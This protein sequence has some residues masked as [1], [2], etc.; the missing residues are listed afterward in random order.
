MDSHPRHLRGLSTR[1]CETTAFIYGLG[2][3]VPVHEAA[4][5]LWALRVSLG[6]A[7]GENR[8]AYQR[9]PT[10]DVQRDAV[11]VRASSRGQKDGRASDVGRRSCSPCGDGF[12]ASVCARMSA[13]RTF[14]H[15]LELVGVEL[16]QLVRGGR[17]LA[18]KQARRDA[19]DSDMQ[20]RETSS[21]DLCQEHHGSLG[22]LC[23]KVAVSA[24]GR[25]DDA[26]GTDLIRGVRSLRVAQISTNWRA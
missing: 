12:S 1:L 18:G 24:T 25:Q 14:R 2:V 4:H 7:S 20:R 21:H 19:V 23:R 5:D 8:L 11:E 6:A 26:R 13:S 3:G 16:A 10:A 9:A 15:R 17:Q 22:R